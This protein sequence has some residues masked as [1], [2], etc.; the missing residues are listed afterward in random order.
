[1]ELHVLRAFP[2]CAETPEPL[3]ALPVTPSASV[4]VR[5]NFATPS[6][7]DSHELAIVGAVRHSVRIAV[8][9]LRALPMRT[10]VVTMECAGNDRLSMHPVPEGEL[11]SHGAVSTVEWRGVPLSAL[12]A[13]AG[14]GA[15]AVEVLVTGADVGALEDAD[16]LV[17]FARSIPLDVALHADTLLALEMNGAPLTADHGAPVRLVVPGWYGMAS[18]K[19]V[20]A[21]TLLVEPF[22]G[23]FQRQRYVYQ[24]GEDVQP[25]TRSLVKSIIT[26]PADGA[27]LHT[28]DEPMILARGWAWSGDGAITAVHVS[29]G[30]GDTWHAAMLGA[31]ASAYAWTPWECALERPSGARGELQLRSRA[32]DASGAVQPERAPWNTLGYGNNAIRHITVQLA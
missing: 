12:L 16:G 32:S 22:T 17:A 25:V 30:D 29:M 11:W 23:Y 8:R 1:M 19:W 2:L 18:V 28:S 3:L 26:T 27:T 13:R 15:G 5:S 4:Y 14:V 10:L 31:P 24:I 6:L 7:D 20:T 21:I 9:Q